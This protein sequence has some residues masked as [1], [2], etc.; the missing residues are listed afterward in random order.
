MAMVVGEPASCILL[1]SGDETGESHHAP[2]PSWARLPEL[3]PPT[4]SLQRP[5]DIFDR[6][7]EQGTCFETFACCGDAYKPADCFCCSVCM[8]FL[9]EPAACLGCHQAICTRCW[10]RHRESSQ[11]IEYI[12]PLC[13]HAQPTVQV[14]R[15]MQQV[16]DHE[17]R[18][19]GIA[20]SCNT[21]APGSR[22]DALWCCQGQFSSLQ[23]LRLHL[24]LALPFRSTRTQLRRLLTLAAS[25]SKESVECLFQDP[26]Q[27]QKLAVVL[28]ED[29][30]V[31]TVA[32]RRLTALRTAGAGS[33][34]RS[35]VAGSSML[36]RRRVVLRHN[37][38]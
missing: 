25:G 5:V 6:F 20:F 13:R 10:E 31:A 23:E 27:R 34:S 29:E 30:V 15:C 21:C 7:A 36:R 4:M 37:G 17:L 35:P 11:S 2:L 32:R 22:P 12:C 16:L 3:T 1:D 33:R 19:K 26:V 38:P 14:S 18:S 28:E 9:E 24:S 8:Q